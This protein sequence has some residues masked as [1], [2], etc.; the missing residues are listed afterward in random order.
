MLKPVKKPRV[1]VLGLTLEIYKDSFPGYL[2]RLQTQ[3]GEF[4]TEIAEAADIVSSRLCY[5]Q[6]Q[7]SAQVREAESENVDALL[8]IPM[9]Y[10]ASLMTSLP[11]SRTSL[12]IVIWNTQEALE[13]SGSY[14]FDDLLMNH[15]TQGTQDVTNVLF[16][17]GKV[18]GMDS[19]HYRDR[20]ALDRLAQWLNA[21][22][23]MQFAKQLRVGLLG[24]PFQDM[25]DFEL[26]EPVGDF[27]T[28]YSM[29][30]G[31]H[32]LTAV[33]GHLSEALRKLAHLQGFRFVGL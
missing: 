27:L 24:Q 23:A 5:V 18:F 26:D 11:L 28:R 29:A 25:G 33:P 2:E 17:T 14:N 16:R 19:G 31:T 4:Q 8:L 1:A 21:A 10:T 15:V 13:V 9:S 6:D 20:E 32:H 12:P 30:G 7:V 22:K 3:L